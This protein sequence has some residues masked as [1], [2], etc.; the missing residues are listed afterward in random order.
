MGFA[1]I[2]GRN[3]SILITLEVWLLA[4]AAACTTV[5]NTSLLSSL[6]PVA[7]SVTSYMQ[8]KLV[9]CDVVIEL[10]DIMLI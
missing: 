6:N 5:R 4:F 3:L 8:D 7:I 2:V 10:T 9:V 1:A